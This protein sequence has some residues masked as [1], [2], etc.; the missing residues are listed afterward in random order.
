MET[1]NHH[2]AEVEKDQPQGASVD[3]DVYELYL[4]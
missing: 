3:P 4:Q 1:A 2:Q